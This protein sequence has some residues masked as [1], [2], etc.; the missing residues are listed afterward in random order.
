MDIQKHA[1]KKKVTR[2]E[3]HVS[4]VSARER[5]ITLYK[6]NIHHHHIYL[7]ID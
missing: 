5:K 6:S 3:S 4:A 2:I 7:C 1:I